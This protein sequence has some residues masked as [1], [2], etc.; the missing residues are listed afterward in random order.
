MLKITSEQTEGFTG[1]TLEGS[2]S[3]PC[4]R[5]GANL[6]DRAAVRHICARRRTGRDHVHL[7]KTARP[8][9]ARMWRGRAALVAHGCVPGTLSVK[10]PE[11]PRWRARPVR[12][13]IE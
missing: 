7:R 11:Q 4:D 5:I 3:G 13:C 6:A 2:L 9:L 1:W 12:P 8:S 10:L